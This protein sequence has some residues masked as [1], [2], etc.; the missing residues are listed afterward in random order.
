MNTVY[1]IYYIL[2][3]YMNVGVFIFV[4]LFIYLNLCVYIQY[5]FV[6]IYCD[7]NVNLS[8]SMLLSMK[9]A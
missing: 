9:K 8:H 3:I 1:T 5:I 4:D 2:F 6:Y 7:K